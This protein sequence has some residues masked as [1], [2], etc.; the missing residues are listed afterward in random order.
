MQS[1]ILGSASLQQAR[2][3]C[4]SLSTFSIFLL[5]VPV[6]FQLWFFSFSFS[7]SCDFSVTVTVIVFQFLFIFHLVILHKICISA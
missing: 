3:V 6:L 5:S 1:E 2:S 7:Y 4:V